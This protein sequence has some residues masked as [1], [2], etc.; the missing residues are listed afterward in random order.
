MNKISFYEAMIEEVRKRAVGNE[1]LKL[2]LEE[3]GNLA[4]LSE[5]VPE[6]ENERYLQECRELTDS[7]FCWKLYDT[8]RQAEDLSE[9]KSV[10][11]ETRFKAYRLKHEMGKLH[12]FK[13]VVP[14]KFPKWFYL[15]EK[16][17]HTN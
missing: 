4:V 6:R 8:L 17:D 3:R 1:K 10:L 7:D 2:G 12:E 13:C 11:A 15:H 9:D 5:L 16:L 14:K